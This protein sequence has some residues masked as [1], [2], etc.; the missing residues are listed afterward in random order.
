M[1][2]KNKNTFS[3]EIAT[4][5]DKAL[6]ANFPEKSRSYWQKM[7]AG[8]YV[9]VN[10]QCVQKGNEKLKVGDVVTINERE[11][12]QLD[13][14]P[15]NIPLNII[16]QDYDV[17][18]INKPRGMVVHPDNSYTSGTLVNALL[19]HLK[20]LSTINGIIRPGIVHRIDKDTSGL[21]IVAKNDMAHL[22]LSEQLKDKSLYREYIA[23]V[24]GDVKEDKFMID[25]PIGRHPQKRKQ[26]A[27]VEN[28]K[29][30]RTH[31]EV[32][33]RYG[34][35]TLVRCQ[36]ETG[37]T[38]QIRVHL[39]YLGYPIVCDPLYNQRKQIFNLAGQFLHAFKLGFM[40][41]TTNK[42]IE[43]E[44]ELPQELQDI[45]TLLEKECD[46]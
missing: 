26:M 33:K 38:H 30:A 41:P 2:I 44:A 24:Q 19:F 14:L 28:G 15:E 35:Y 12:K 4:R 21:I 3:P 9:F 25:L 46:E 17:A 5:L 45:L 43:F 1:E 29:D 22:K 6:A 23:L 39:Q 37:R 31:V 8:G 10:E 36:L 13:I 11:E 27:V 34:D 42:Q 32:L 7:I 40:H 20:D 18:V 16:Y